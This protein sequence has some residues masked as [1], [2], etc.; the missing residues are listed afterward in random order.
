MLPYTKRQAASLSLEMQLLMAV[1]INLI[2]Q[3]VSTYTLQGIL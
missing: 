3:Q 2:I 1:L